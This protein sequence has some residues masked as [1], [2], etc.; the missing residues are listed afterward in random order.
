MN[1]INNGHDGFTFDTI[2]LTE[3]SRSKIKHLIDPPVRSILINFSSGTKLQTLITST[4]PLTP[5]PQGNCHSPVSK[6]R[7]VAGLE[8]TPIHQISAGTSHS[9]AWTAIPTDRKV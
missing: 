8:N 4:L 1:L 7:R 2:S 6:P 5:S 3:F 9:V